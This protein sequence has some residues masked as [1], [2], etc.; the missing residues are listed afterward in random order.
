LSEL[1][2]FYFK[3]PAKDLDKPCVVLNE[4][5]FEE[6]PVEFSGTSNLER[7]LLKEGQCWQMLNMHIPFEIICLTFLFKVCLPESFNG[8]LKSDEK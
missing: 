7:L 6:R 8:S 2:Q 5:N 4:N 3:N 1:P